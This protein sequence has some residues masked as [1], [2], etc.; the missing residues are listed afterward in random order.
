VYQRPKHYFL[1]STLSQNH[2]TVA[3]ESLVIYSIN[4]VGRF[5]SSGN[6]MILCDISLGFYYAARIGV[7]GL[8]STGKVVTQYPS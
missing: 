1:F 7:L 5:V 8:N 2:P 4:K 3:N 6:K